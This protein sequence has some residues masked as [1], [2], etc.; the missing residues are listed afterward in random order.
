[1]LRLVL[2]VSALGAAFLS[3][4]SIAAPADSSSQVGALAEEAKAVAPLFHSELVARFLGGVATLPRVDPRTVYCD[5]ART[6]CWTDAEAAAL[7]DS[8]RT[9]LA[10]LLWLARNSLATRTVAASGA[11]RNNAGFCTSQSAS[12][13]FCWE[14]GGFVRAAR[15]S[16]FFTAMTAS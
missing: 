12:T 5:S 3:G 14:L 7:P 10:M 16:C 8:Q 13:E 6:H 15:L 1:M 4:A 11:S 2:A 9:R